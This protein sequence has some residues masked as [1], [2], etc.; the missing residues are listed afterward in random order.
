MN[1]IRVAFETALA[2]SA[3]AQ[4]AYIQQLLPGASEPNSSA[5][6]D[7]DRLKDEKVHDRYLI[8]SDAKAQKIEQFFGSSMLK[9]SSQSSSQSDAPTDD[10]STA[11]DPDEQDASENL[12]DTSESV[13]EPIPHSTTDDRID[14]AD[15]SFS[16]IADSQM[17]SSQ[18]SVI[19]STLDDTIQRVSN[20]DRFRIVRRAA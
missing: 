9:S 10:Q 15:I 19:S 4:K 12:D 5:A 8:R 14:T 13:L 17:Q 7:D 18:Q 6:G 20:Y 2:S 1:N 3:R 11:P 16:S